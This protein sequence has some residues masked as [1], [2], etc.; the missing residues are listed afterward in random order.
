MGTLVCRVELNKTTG[1][2]IKVENADGKITQT[3][4]MDGTTMTLKCLGEQA[5]STIVQKSDSIAITCKTF[6][7]DADTIT[8][9]STKATKHESKDVFD[10]ISTKDMSLTSSAKLV[11]KATSDCNISGSNVA[12]K[13]DIKVSLAAPTVEGTA[14]GSAKLSGA[15]LALSG[16]ATAELKAPKV[17]VTADGMLTVKSSGIATF[18]GSATSLKGSIL[19]IGS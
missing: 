13:G 16:T 12:V 18:Q 14:D 9:T 5:T 19:N 1:I 7:L 15:Q 3:V 2:T 17:D 6:T 8:C 10:L 11:E 4:T